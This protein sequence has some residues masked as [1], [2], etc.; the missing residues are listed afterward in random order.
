MSDRGYDNDDDPSGIVTVEDLRTMRRQRDQERERANA[1]EQARQ[2][3]ERE[4]DEARGG[5]ANEVQARFAA[6]DQAIDGQIASAETEAEAL[7]ERI[8][9]LNAEGSFSE[10]A[11]VQRQLARAEARLE[12]LGIRKNSLAEMRAYQEQHAQA[13]QQQASDKYRGMTPKQRAWC[14]QHPLFLDDS[15]EGK[16]YTA[17]VQR[18]HWQA[19][20]EDIPVDSDEYYDLLNAAVENQ[21][22]R[23]PVR[24]FANDAV[25]DPYYENDN[26]HQP[27]GRYAQNRAPQMPVTRRASGGE[28]GNAP[29]RLSPDQREAADITMPEIPVDDYVDGQGVQQPGRYRRYAMYYVQ[30][31]QEGRIQ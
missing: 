29:V 7:T 1:A 10:S 9:Q 28:S 13:R 21:R 8:A 18:A 12:N 6:E 16:R 22:A 17:H 20:S 27:Q 14:E 4:R 19:V 23:Q 2:R 30:Q 26:G 24:Q 31:R 3:A 11:K 25:G 5:A 15:R